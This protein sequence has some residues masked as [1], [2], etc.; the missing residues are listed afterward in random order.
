MW[1]FVRLIGLGVSSVL[2]V[3]L[4]D[5]PA[6]AASA[7]QEEA[8]EI[9]FERSAFYL[10]VAGSFGHPYVVDQSDFDDAWG[11]DILAGYRAQDHFAIEGEFEAFWNFQGDGNIQTWAVTLN[12]K[13]PFFATRRF[14]PFLKYGMGFMRAEQDKFNRKGTDFTMRMGGGLDVYATDHF[15]VNTTLDYVRGFGEV[16]DYRYMSLRLGVFYRF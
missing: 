1:R 10:G 6:V 9:E 11:F 5:L 8:E 15:G 13:V 7:P 4:L 3:L 2:V 14:Q 12:V 16:R